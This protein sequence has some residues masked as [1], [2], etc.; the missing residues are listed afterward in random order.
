MQTH[1]KLQEVLYSVIAVCV[2]I[3]AI[4]YVQVKSTVTDNTAPPAVSQNE[5]LAQMS[6]SLTAQQVTP[7]LRAKLQEMSASLNK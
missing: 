2:I 4:V 3:W 5:Q 1:K 7:Q 6:Q